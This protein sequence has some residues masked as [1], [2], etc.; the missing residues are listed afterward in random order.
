MY[1]CTTPAITAQSVYTNG[2]AR[3]GPTGTVDVQ[4]HSTVFRL[5]NDSTLHFQEVRDSMTEATLWMGHL[6]A[7]H[8]PQGHDII[9]VHAG[10]K[11]IEALDTRS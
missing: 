1:G 11:V 5:I 9:L 6:F 8:D 7:S 3:T 4:T 2:E 10:D